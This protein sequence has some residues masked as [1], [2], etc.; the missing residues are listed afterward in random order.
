M[1]IK[2]REPHINLNELRVYVHGRPKTGKS[3]LFACREDTVYVDINGGLSH[4]S[5]TATDRCATWEGIS[6]ALV[7]IIERKDEEGWRF[8]VIDTINEAWELLCN[9]VAK[10]NNVRSGYIG[11][12]PHGKGWHAARVRM[13]EALSKIYNSGLGYA[14]I[15][16]SQMSTINTPYQ[17]EVTR[18]VPVIG[19]KAGEA[20]AGDCDFMLFLDVR[21]PAKKGDK[22]EHILYTSQGPFHEAGGRHLEQMPEALKLP[23]P[24]SG[25]DQFLELLKK[26]TAK[27]KQGTKKSEKPAQGK[28]QKAEPPAEESVEEPAEE[29]P[30]QA[31]IT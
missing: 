21:A 31:E 28:T 13:L 8:V 23:P 12:I 11:D 7:E 5:V 14:L 9:R 4:L 29:Q 16:H 20:I 19:G 1:S 24:P 27:K 17:P 3:S 26:A 30:A 6:D 22:P 2:H 10:Q 18:F 25:W 15:S